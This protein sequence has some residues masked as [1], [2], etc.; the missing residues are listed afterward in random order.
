MR[1]S[2]T[3]DWLQLL[4]NNRTDFIHGWGDTARDLMG[5]A[6]YAFGTDIMCRFAQELGETDDY[7]SYHAQYLA[8][9]KAFQNTFELR[10]HHFRDATQTGYAL[11]LYFNLLS[12]DMRGYVAK[13]LADDVRTHNDSLTTGI[14]G[15]AYV[16]QALSDNGYHDT[17]VRTMSSDEYPGFGYMVRMGATTC[18]ER[19]DSL[20]KEYGAHPH[21]MNSYSHIGLSSA[22]AW[23]FQKIG[24]IEPLEPGFRRV[25]IAPCT[26]GSL[27]SADVA[28]TCIYGKIN[29][30]WE[31]NADGTHYCIAIPPNVTAEVLIPAAKTTI[32]S[33]RLI[34]DGKS[35]DT[36]RLIAKSGTHNITVR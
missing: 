12:D 33:D 14:A 27:T 19:W 25:K 36:L 15:S 21:V 30:S 26:D 22:G 8:T 5:T 24:G 28:F 31:K 1:N 23:L 9:R 32:R 11:A 29:V 7:E 20:H 2:I 16:L 18:W 13:Y 6:F 34:D 10:E 17:A 4:K 35:E 3:G